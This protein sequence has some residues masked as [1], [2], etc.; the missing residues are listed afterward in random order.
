MLTY[1]G[2]KNEFKYIRN[3][4]PHLS[5]ALHIP[6]HGPDNNIFCSTTMNKAVNIVTKSPVATVMKKAVADLA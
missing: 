3:Y 1:G 6:Y 2:R 5:Y 4:M